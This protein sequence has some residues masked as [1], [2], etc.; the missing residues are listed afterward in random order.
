[1]P[2]TND[3]EFY[4]LHLSQSTAPTTHD[5]ILGE[6]P[7]PYPD[8]PEVDMGNDWENAWDLGLQRPWETDTNTGTT[9]THGYVYPS[10]HLGASYITENLGGETV[11]GGWDSVDR[12]TFSLDEGSYLNAFTDHDAITELVRFEADGTINALAT[13]EYGPRLQ[14]WLEP[15][16][17]GF[18]FFTEGDG[19]EINTALDWSNADPD[20]A[21]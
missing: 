1:M 20:Y 19:A 4:D 11:G 18:S 17:Y 6:P 21:D 7:W 2:N 13:V 9:W 12:L 14:T 16:N 8:N 3:Y 5:P 10:Y 15:G